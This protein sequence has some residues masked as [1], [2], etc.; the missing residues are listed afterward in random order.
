MGD[1]L[2]RDTVP[3]TP[4]ARRISPFRGAILKK[5][6]DYK[7]TYEESERMLR[8]HL[9]EIKKKDRIATFIAAHGKHVMTEDDIVDAM[10]VM[11]LQENGSRL[12][13]R[14]ME[15]TDS[16]HIRESARRILK[17]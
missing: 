4:Q 12:V 7:E 15:T 10:K 2:K 3:A 8:Q 17:R 1:A 11:A 16:E 5:L 13:S 14:V 6:Q 9:S